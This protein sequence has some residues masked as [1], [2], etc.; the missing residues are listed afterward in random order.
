MNFG[1]KSG[2][3]GVVAFLPF[4]AFICESHHAGALSVKHFC[5]L[6]CPVPGWHA[7]GLMHLSY[8]EDFTLF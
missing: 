1:R 5:F 4:V 8:F 6:L 2:D 3:G 7:N